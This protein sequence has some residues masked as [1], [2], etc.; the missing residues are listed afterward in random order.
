MSDFLT[1]CRDLGI[2]IDAVPEPSNT[3]VRMDSSR[4]MP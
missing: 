2:R 3:S 1:F 4:T